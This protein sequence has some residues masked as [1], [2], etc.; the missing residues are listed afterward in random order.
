MGSRIEKCNWCGSHVRLLFEAQA[1]SCPF[2][3]AHNTLRP[4]NDN[5]YTNPTA[6][7]NNGYPNNNNGYPNSNNGYTNPA[8]SWNNGYTNPAASWN[9]GYVNGGPYNKVNAVAPPMY[10][11]PVPA[12]GNTLQSLPVKG[13]KRAVLCGLSYY[14]T[15]NILKGSAN[16]INY[17]RYFLIQKMGFPCESIFVLTE[18]ETNPSRI[19]TIRNMRVALH[20]LIQGCQPGDSLVFYYCGHGSR[21]HDLDNDERDGFDEALCPVDYRTGG[22]L[23]DDEINDTIV[24][25]LPRKAKLHAIIDTCYSGTCLDLPFVCKINGEQHYKWEDHHSQHAYK[26]TSG[27]KAYCFSA[28][29]DHQNA[30]DTTDFTGNTAIGAFT[31]SFIDTLETQPQLTYG[32]LLNSMHRKISKIQQEVRLNNPNAHPKPQE[33]ILSS[34]VGFD[35]HSTIFT[36]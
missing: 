31:Q 18:D 23:L 13:R 36:L 22:K 17:M 34:T 21:V 33:P 19:P 11:Y 16:N 8:A 4:Y 28:C 25:P 2:C 15:P 10:S 12:Y 3:R 14:G 29:D 5:G 6:Y 24:K 30:A 7:W 20:W 35:I 27:G 9:N 1:F 32:S 26:G